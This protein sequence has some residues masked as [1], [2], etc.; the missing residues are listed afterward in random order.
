MKNSYHTRVKMIT[1]EN[2]L[3]IVLT[4]EFFQYESIKV[5]GKATVI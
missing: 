5:N 4:C 3:V 2:P 1:I